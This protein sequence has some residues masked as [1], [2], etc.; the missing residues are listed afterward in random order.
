VESLTGSR[1]LAVDDSEVNL[2][3]LQAILED[4]GYTEVVT[5]SDPHRALSVCQAFDPD[6]LLLDLHMPGLSG[7][8]VIA[9]VRQRKSSTYLPIL[10]LTADVSSEA[11]VRALST[12]A[13]DFLTKPF[14]RTEVELRIR[15][16]LQMR[17]LH[18]EL[19]KQNAQLEAK[20]ADRTRQVE[21]VKLE[22]LERLAMAAEF[23]DDVTGRHTQR[24]GN[25]AALIAQALGLPD[26]QVESIRR[27]APLHDIG[28]IGIPDSILLK[29]GELS[30]AEKE[31]MKRHTVIGARLLSNSSS[32]TLQLAEEIAATHHERWDGTGYGSGLSADSIPI[33]G[34]ILA[35]A[36]V[37][38]ALTHVRPYKDAWSCEDAVAEI[39]SQRERQ[40]D[41]RVVDAFVEVEATNDLVDTG[42]VSRHLIA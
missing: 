2:E 11:K 23:R 13:N 14:D 37:F 21:A 24:V 18:M 17:H 39:R 22:I 35:V 12:G 7:L 19:H 27:A 5:V 26:A 20:V 30:P 40:F 1:I 10:M 34:R 25:I 31:L 8:D 38:D 4:I 16:L 28:K 42:E 29:E 9:A 36:D 15:N 33:S 3:V 41:P 6:L 32:G